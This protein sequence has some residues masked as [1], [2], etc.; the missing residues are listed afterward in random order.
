MYGW[1]NQGLSA[2]KAAANA[3][4]KFF[5]DLW[6]VTVS[7]YEGARRRVSA[8]MARAAFQV[9]S[10]A[11]QLAETQVLRRYHSAEQELFQQ[12]LHRYRN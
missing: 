9:A 4:T 1:A 11:Y 7:A 12:L 6:E 2:A 3:L 5:H 8:A 10:T